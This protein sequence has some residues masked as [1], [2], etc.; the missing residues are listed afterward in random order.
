MAITT[1]RNGLSVVSVATKMSVVLPILFGLIYYKESSGPLKILG[2]VLA[3]IAVYLVSLKNSSEIS[4]VKNNG[5]LLPILVFLGS[6]II[7]TSI[8]FLED[9]FVAEQDV[10]LFSA[11]IFL[12]AFV[13]GIAVLF[14]QIIKNKQ[15]LAFKNIIGGFALG[16]PNYYSIYFLVQALRHPTLESST[17]FTLNN[18]GIV[19]VATLIGILFFKE[20]L[21]TK[22]WI[23]IAIAVVSIILIAVVKS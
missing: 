3:L 23:G 2:I 17:V 12:T 9:S 15:H 14:Y 8:K 4:K 20:K 7:D 11:M 6:G 13:L 21:S 16:I 18:V 22:N 5:L 10:P 19:M 1:Q